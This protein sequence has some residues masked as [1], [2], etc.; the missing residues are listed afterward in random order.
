[1]DLAGRYAF[2]GLI[3]LV[4]AMIEGLWM[5]ATGA[6]QYL[7]LHIVMVLSG[8]V[9]GI[10]FGTLMR[11]W[12]KLAGDRWAAPQFILWN[13]AVLVQAVGAIV[14]AWGWGDALIGVASVV[15]LAAAV[16]MLVMFYRSTEA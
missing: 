16:M 8:G 11:A 6:M 9:V 15:V 7:N 12:P 2:V 4:A 13:A 10:A 1:M 14:R 3:W 5:G